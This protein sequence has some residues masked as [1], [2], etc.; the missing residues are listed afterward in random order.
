MWQ[1]APQSFTDLAVTV[2][3]QG[4]MVSRTN[5]HTQLILYLPLGRI[6]M[7]WHNNNN[8]NNNNITKH[9]HHQKKKKSQKHINIIF[10]NHLPNV[11]LHIALRFA[12]W[13]KMWSLS[14]ASARVIPRRQEV[15]PTPAQDTLGGGFIGKNW[16]VCDAIRVS[17][18]PCVMINVNLTVFSLFFLPLDLY[19]ICYIDPPRSSVSLLQG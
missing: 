3:R 18:P 5:T 16:S 15:Q 11:S 12:G 1:A 2:V 4:L 7:P 10:H 14:S 6:I 8:N 17:C 19:F 13:R 9:Q